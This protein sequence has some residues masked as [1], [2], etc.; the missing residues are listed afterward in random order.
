V[1]GL[2]ADET[3]ATPE[4]YDAITALEVVGGTVRVSTD[5]ILDAR[6]REVVRTV[7]GALLDTTVVPFEEVLVYDEAGVLAA[8][9]SR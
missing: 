1:A 2:G 9:C 4:W 6:G 7:C 3:G 5:L 8:E